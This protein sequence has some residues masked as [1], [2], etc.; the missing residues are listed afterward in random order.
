MQKLSICLVLALVGG[1]LVAG[2]G[3]AT[4]TSRTQTIP[5]A[6]ATPLTATTTTPT[7][8]KATSTGTATGAGTRPPHQRRRRQGTATGARPSYRLERL[9]QESAK[10]CRQVLAKRT[11]SARQRARLEKIC[12]TLR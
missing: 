1:A 5:A 11:L 9:K 4:T 7:A 2:C 3:S 10:A 6:G 12:K 8:A